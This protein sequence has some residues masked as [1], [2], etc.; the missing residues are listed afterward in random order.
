MKFLESQI[1]QEVYEEKDESVT[2]TLDEKD[3][4]ILELLQKDSKLKLED[5]AKDP[6]VHLS[7]PTVRKRIKNLEDCGII[8]KWTVILNGK[9]LGRDVTAFIGVD[10]NYNI[11]GSTGTKSRFYDERKPLCT[12]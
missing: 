12:D 3:R 7:I 8:N 2:I 10:I 1:A 6:G 4:R 5:I 9:K 11:P